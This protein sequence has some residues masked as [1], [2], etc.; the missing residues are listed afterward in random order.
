[1]GVNALI[2]NNGLKWPQVI[3]SSHHH[4]ECNLPLLL[5]ISSK[6]EKEARRD[7][8][9]S[10]FVE[11]QAASCKQRNVIDNNDRNL[12]LLLFSSFFLRSFLFVDDIGGA[13]KR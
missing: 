6:F 9:H 12:V 8:S 4:Q 3:I 10:I 13:Q 2:S 5:P 7:K 11:F 1:V